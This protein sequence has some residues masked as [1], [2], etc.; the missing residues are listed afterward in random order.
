MEDRIVTLIYMFE[1][2]LLANF[3]EGRGEWKLPWFQEGWPF[4]RIVK[5]F[6]TFFCGCHFEKSILGGMGLLNNA[7]RL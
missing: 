3:N 6:Q 7:R 2:I 4:D 1:I 5:L